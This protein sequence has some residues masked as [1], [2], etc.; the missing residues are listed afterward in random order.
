MKSALH[1]PISLSTLSKHAAHRYPSLSSWV[2]A[3]F[4]NAAPALPCPLDCIVTI[5]LLASRVSAAVKFCRRVVERLMSDRCRGESEKKGTHRLGS[6]SSFPPPE[7]TVSGP[8]QGCKAHDMKRFTRVTWCRVLASGNAVFVKSEIRSYSGK[9]NYGLRPAQFGTSTDSEGAGDPLPPKHNCRIY[10]PQVLVTK[11]SQASDRIPWQ[12]LRLGVPRRIPK[13]LSG[14][15]PLDPVSS[16][17]LLPSHIWKPRLPA[18][19]SILHRKASES[20]E[21]GFT[22]VFP[23]E[24]NRSERIDVQH[25]GTLRSSHQNDGVALT[26]LL[27]HKDI[28][29]FA[30]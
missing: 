4:A 2:T 1:S 21:L 22:S 19:T 28:H 7:P 11:G 30:D 25:R 15:S 9:P 24:H 17:F 5:F 20:T 14:S 26:Y 8:C 18:G 16:Q 3:W 27:K 23:C 6:V 13:I 10:Q 12:Q 29:H